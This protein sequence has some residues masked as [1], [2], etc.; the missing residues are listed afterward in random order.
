[1]F[2]RSSASSGVTVIYGK[3]YVLVNQNKTTIKTQYADESS[4]EENTFRI[5]NTKKFLELSAM[6][7][8]K[9]QSQ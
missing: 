1:M 9:Y 7:T 3:C 8:G 6:F 2:P 5:A 4:F